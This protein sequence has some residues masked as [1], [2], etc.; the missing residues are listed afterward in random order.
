M[1]CEDVHA[2]LADHLSGAL[3]PAVTEAVARHLAD[4]RACASEARAF[5]DTWEMLGAIPSESP[6]A[7]MR[8][9]FEAMLDGYQAG[10]SRRSAWSARWRQTA[11]LTATAALFLIGIVFGRQTAAGPP[12]DPQLAGPER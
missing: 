10:V 5:A 9:R 11:Y 6:R 7:A 4:C 1:E 3:P 12:P 2:H 8:A